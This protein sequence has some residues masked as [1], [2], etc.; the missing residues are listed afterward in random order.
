MQ[1][2]LSSI[3]TLV[4]VSISL[5]DIK[6]TMNAFSSLVQEWT[7]VS[8]VMQSSSKELSSLVSDS[9]CKLMKA[10]NTYAL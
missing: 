2:V 9:E 3:W 10:N 8:R 6:Y 7:V 1:T 5:D 4:A